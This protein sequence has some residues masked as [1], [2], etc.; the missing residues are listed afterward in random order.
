MIATVRSSTPSLP[1]VVAVPA[2]PSP[3]KDWFTL[4]GFEPGASTGKLAA[5][6]VAGGVLGSA[7][8]GFGTR[9]FTG[10]TE[11]LF[12]MMN[13]G[14][15]GMAVGGALGAAIATL[16][17]HMGE[18]QKQSGS[19]GTALVGGVLGVVSGAIGGSLAGAYMGHAVGNVLGFMAG[20]V[21]GGSAAYLVARRHFA[22]KT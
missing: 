13:G 20:G 8:V 6:T 15:A 5:A 11:V 16:V 21:V 10:P 7:V 4:D 1:P 14:F 18:D 2:K 12:G 19:I 17:G 3:L 9:Y 22:A